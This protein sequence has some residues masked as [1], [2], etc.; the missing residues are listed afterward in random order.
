M[1][2]G[3]GLIPQILTVSLVADGDF[4]AAL[5]A[6]SPWPVGTEIELH[7]SG[8]SSG[9]VVWA[10]VVEGSRADWDVPADDVA[11]VLSSQAT[12]ARLLYK[13]A[14]GTALVWAKGKINAY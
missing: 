9:V 7:L 2:I 5:V 12:T 11:A 6:T 1:T 4:V 3:L 8:G 13:E 10:A 14:D